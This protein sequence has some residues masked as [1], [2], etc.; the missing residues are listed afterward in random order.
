MAVRPAAGMPGRAL[1]DAT[2]RTF[3]VH[4]SQASYIHRGLASRVWDR[5]R[6]SWSSERRG[7]VKARSTAHTYISI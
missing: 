4:P 6:S 2:R 5:S 7:S 1:A 3:A